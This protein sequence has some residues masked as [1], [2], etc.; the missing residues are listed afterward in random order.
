MEIKKRGDIMREENW[1]VK[2][3]KL[4]EAKGRLGMVEQK[5][6]ASLISEIKAEDKD[7]KQ[8][9][10]EI[11]DIAEFM[12]LSSKAVYDQIKTAARNL[13]NKE[14][15]I[16]NVDERGKKSFL[17]TSLLS[18]ARYKEGEG[19]LEVY[20]DPNLKPYLLAINGKNTYFTKYMIKNILKLNSSYSIRIYELLKQYEKIGKREFNTNELKELLGAN[21]KSYN[22]FDNFERRVLKVA[23]VEINEKTDIWIDYEKIKEGRRIGKIK[24]IIE[25]K[26]DKEKALVDALYDKQEIEKIKRK[27][28]L[29]GTNFNSKQI[30]EL[31]EI[32]VKKTES[33][34]IDPHEYIKLNY[35]NM[36][37]NNTARNK[38][39]WL[40]KALEN[41]YA[42][43]GG[44]LRFDY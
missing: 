40:K 35:N 23:K 21:E 41:D 34:D 25:G 30:M 16:E 38:F 27:C 5:L 17:V 31:Y 7:F 33:A 12:K 19:Y 15:V 28:G 20:I 18:S 14:I 22:R 2:A 1:V 39:A 13:R 44:Q 4:I 9:I 37:N 8:Y 26:I 29:N 6:F 36:I 42:V 43:A 3:N 24:F 11:K 32:A 10:L